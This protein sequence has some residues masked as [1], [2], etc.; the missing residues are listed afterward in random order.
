MANFRFKKPELT[1]FSIGRERFWIGVFAGVLTAIALSLLMNHWREVM[2]YI[3]TLDADLIQPD[4]QVYWWLSLFFTA[5]SSSLGLCISV[6]I[7][8]GNNRHALKGERLRRR[9]AQTYAMLTFWVMI[10]VA[11]RFGTIWSVIQGSVA[12]LNSHL[13]YYRVFVWILVILPLV[14]F[15]QSW[16]TVRL[17]YRAGR[18]IGYSSLACALLV[19][20]L[21]KTTT[22]DPQHINKF[23]Q[24]AFQEDFA[25]IDQEVLQAAILYGITFSPET[26]G[27][28][29]QWHSTESQKQVNR[30]K[31]A[32]LTTRK[33]PLDT[34]ILQKMVIHNCKMGNRHPD[35]SF[36][37]P[38]WPY[39]EPADI[40]KQISLY[41]SDAN[42]TIELFEILREMVV[43]FNTS[44]MDWGRSNKIGITAERKAI[45]AHSGQRHVLVHHLKETIES[46]HI[47]PKYRNFTASL[48]EILE[49]MP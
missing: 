49:P 32:F 30:I 4:S 31:M 25:Y 13:P 23:Y 47:D 28:L 9:V 5:L 29:K 24:A 12:D 36:G 14:I 11:G 48:P 22:V 2:R 42:E 3:N 1:I 8:M 43:F 26:I 45:S 6:W 35:L 38:H 40:A 39:A 44:P 21:M 46:L 10:M 17:T 41:P 15:F 7:W 20:I 16:Y 18:F 19:L 37:Y 27:V 34:I 33:V